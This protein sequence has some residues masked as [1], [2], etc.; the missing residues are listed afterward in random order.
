[1]I[2]WS[3]VRRFIHRNSYFCAMGVL[4][5]GSIRLFPIGSLR[6][7]DE[8]SATYFELYAR[9]TEAGTPL[10]CLAVNMSPWF[11]LSSLVKGKF[12][13]P[14]AIRLEGEMGER[15]QATDAEKKRFHRAVGWLRWTKGGRTLWPDAKFSREV[16]FHTARPLMTGKMTRGLEHWA[17][18]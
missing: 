4:E 17:E 6:F 11:W 15:R 16:Q 14:P 7:S 18:I 10:S 5:K 1:M 12:D 2:N 3:A 9:P 13:L 8:G